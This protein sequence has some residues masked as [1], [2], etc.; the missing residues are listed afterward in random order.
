MYANLFILHKMGE[1]CFDIVMYEE[2]NLLCLLHRTGKKPILMKNVDKAIL[3]EIKVHCKET[4]LVT[5]NFIK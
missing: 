5:S 1:N 4:D 2:V 3:Y